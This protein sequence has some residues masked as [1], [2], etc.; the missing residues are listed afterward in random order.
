MQISW[1]G[2]STNYSQAGQLM[3]R[4]STRQTISASSFCLL[5]PSPSSPSPTLLTPPSKGTKVKMQKCQLSSLKLKSFKISE[6]QDTA[7][8]TGPCSAIRC[9]FE[10]SAHQ[11]QHFFKS[12]TFH[13]HSVIQ[14]LLKS[15][16]KVEKFEWLFFLWSVATHRNQYEQQR[17]KPREAFTHWENQFLTLKIWTS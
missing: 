7:G 10:V 15:K 11:R 14:N 17:P 4:W 9:Y 6:F 5:S 8:W 13:P 1:V 12:F 2:W 16:T 3:A